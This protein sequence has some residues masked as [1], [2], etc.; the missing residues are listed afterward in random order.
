MPEK[1]WP[2]VSV[3]PHNLKLYEYLLTAKRAEGFTFITSRELYG[4]MPLDP[5]KRYILIRHDLDYAPERLVPV[6]DIERRLGIR[7]DIDVVISGQHYDPAPYVAEWRKLAEESFAI[8]VHTV[9]PQEDDF[10]S[11]LRKEIETFQKMLGFP[12]RTFSIHGVC[13]SPANWK[14]RRMRFLERIGGRLESFG[15]TGSHNIGGISF[16]V[17]DSGRG[18]E[19]SYICR[20]FIECEPEPGQVMGMLMHPDHWLE[21]PIGWVYDAA[22]IKEHPELLALI[23]SGRPSIAQ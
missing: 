18:G 10:F 2:L 20:D 8:G 11:V 15:F 22:E 12:P 7:S 9:A 21:W 5:S 17:E 4:E 1:I 14:Q 16:W 19:F 23:K 3:S 6:I 13:P